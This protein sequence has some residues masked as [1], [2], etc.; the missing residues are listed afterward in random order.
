M[1]LAC[2]SCTPQL[3]QTERVSGFVRNVVAITT[4]VAVI[5]LIGS[6]IAMF[7]LH[8]VNLG[9][10]IN[11]L[12]HAIGNIPTMITLVSSTIVVLVSF[13]FISQIRKQNHLLEKISKLSS[14]LKKT[15]KLKHVN[16]GVCAMRG[17][18]KFETK[19]A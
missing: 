16:F 8:G 7:A 5:S 13:W 1:R 9:N 2:C 3:K 19:G 4:T 14:D 15:R 12:A 10:S 18:V 17:C 6:V 11:Q